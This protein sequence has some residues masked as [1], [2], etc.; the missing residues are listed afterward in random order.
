MMIKRFFR[1]K[2]TGE[3]KAR[4]AERD[5]FA[6]AEAVQSILGPIN[7]ALERSEAERTGLKRRLDEVTSHAAIVAGNDLDD[8]LTRTADRSQMLDISD[9]E[10]QRSEARLKMIDQNISHFKFLKTAVYTR[11]PDTKR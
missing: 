8:Y 4:A 9:V 10:M 3:F 2:S 7:L 5:I 6:D 11:F 1:A